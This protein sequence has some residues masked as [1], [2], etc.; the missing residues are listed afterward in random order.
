MEKRG[1]LVAIS[2]RLILL[3]P[4][5][6][7]DLDADTFLSRDGEERADPD[8]RQKLTLVMAPKAATIALLCRAG[9]LQNARFRR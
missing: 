9:S 3:S 1:T 8:G 4:F 7:T 6:H 5:G 2:T